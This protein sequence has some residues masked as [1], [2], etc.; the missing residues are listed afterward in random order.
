M[1]SPSAI[2]HHWNGESSSASDIERSS[3][4]SNG[5]GGDSGTGVG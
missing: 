2:H 5:N 4:A 1:S 3:T